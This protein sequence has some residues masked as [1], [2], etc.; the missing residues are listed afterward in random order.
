MA[1][2]NGLLSFR[3]KWHSENLIDPFKRIVNLGSKDVKRCHATS[4]R[5]VLDRLQ[6]LI[7]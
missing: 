7:S 1:L 5:F 4:N 6:K 2:M 3:A